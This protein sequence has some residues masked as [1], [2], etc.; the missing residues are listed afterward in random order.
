MARHDWRTRAEL[1]KYYDRCN[2]S[3]MRVPEFGC[4]KCGAARNLEDG[5]ALPV[6]GC[7]DLDGG[8]LP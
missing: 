4:A 5:D 2:V 7:L 6:D 8:A 3:P 1:E